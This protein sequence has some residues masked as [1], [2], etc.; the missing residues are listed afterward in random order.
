[1]RHVVLVVIVALIAVAA[2]AQ[3]T[4][5]FL[6]AG[7]LINCTTNEPKFSAQTAEVGDPLLCHLSQTYFLG[8]P[9]LPRGSYMT[10]HLDDAEAP[11]RLVGKG[12]MTISFDRLVLPGRG[13]I[14][15]SAKI[16]S[17][18]NT[19]VAPNGVIHGKG[20]AKRDA[21]EWGIPVLWPVKI[22]NLPRRGPYPTLK[23][24]KRIMMRLLEDVVL[25]PTQAAVPEYT[26]LPAPQATMPRL[27]QRGGAKTLPS[28][29]LLNHQTYVAQS[30][31]IQ[32]D[33]L[34]WVSADDST[35][36]GGQVYTSPI[37]NL[38]LNETVR[39]N[40]LQG[41]IFTLKGWQRVE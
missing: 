35:D 9:M 18:P 40:R 3:D 38:D 2:V 36:G 29:A 17:V 24:E 39:L 33:K 19:K 30:Y 26:P 10:G 6:P 27:K 4:T 15:L 23:G 20:H 22:L 34:M 1:M 28:I 32:G 11:G 41:I 25:P 8:R 13:V 14:P 37:A 16:V 7:L 12:S 21:V 31:A 5:N